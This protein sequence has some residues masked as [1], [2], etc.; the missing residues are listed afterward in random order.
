MTDI[1]VHHGRRLRRPPRRSD[2]RTW[3]GTAICRGTARSRAGAC[4]SCPARAVRVRRLPGADERGGRPGRVAQEEFAAAQADVRRP[5][6]HDFSDRSAVANQLENVGRDERDRCRMIPLQA[7]PAPLSRE[8]AGA[9]NPQLVAFTGRQ[10]PEG[11][12]DGRSPAPD[13]A[14]TRRARKRRACPR[15]EA[16][17]PSPSAPRPAWCPRRFP[18]AA[19]RAASPR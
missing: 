19:G 7:A 8:P 12:Y 15:R 17:R 5:D 13:S 9:E 4:G 11:S 18:S 10:V 14:A 1:N 3:P 16:S 2:S 6:A